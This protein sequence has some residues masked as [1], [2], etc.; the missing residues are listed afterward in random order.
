MTAGRRAVLGGPAI[1]GEEDAVDG[2]NDAVA[3]LGV[4][5]QVEIESKY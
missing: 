1:E 4:A 3:C 2:V 5:A